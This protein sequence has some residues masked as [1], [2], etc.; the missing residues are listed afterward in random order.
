MHGKL[1]AAIVSKDSESMISSARE[2]LSVGADL[3]EFRLDHLAKLEDDL[4]SR[5]DEFADRCIITLR[6][7]SQGGSFAGSES[8]R[9]RLLK[10]FSSINPL[11]LDVE[12][13]AAKR[14]PELVKELS[15]KCQNLIISFHDFK[16]TPDLNVLVGVYRDAIRLGAVS[17]IVTTANSTQDNVTVL[18]LYGMAKAEGNLISFAM[19]EIG[20][21]T[22]VLCLYMGS[23]LSYVSFGKASAPGQI[24]LEMMRKLISGL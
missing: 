9:L 16:S 10:S 14:N 23:P 17:K 11:Y 18:S 12:L 13:D 2:A 6:E 1:C 24:P 21:L 3:V 15:K 20:A 8:E 7:R 5:L 22:R 4:P 19:G